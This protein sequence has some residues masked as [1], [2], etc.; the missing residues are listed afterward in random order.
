[1][2]TLVALL[3]AGYTLEISGEFEKLYSSLSRVAST[4]L[5]IRANEELHSIDNSTVA[6]EAGSVFERK[7]AHDLNR[8]NF[9]DRTAA[10]ASKDRHSASGVEAT[11]KA[12][13]VEHDNEQKRSDDVAAELAAVRAELADR[14]NTEA[15]A[16]KEL[17]DAANRL[18]ANEK[19]WAAK[20]N[21]EQERSNAVARDLAA[22]RAEL[23]YRV[24]MDAAARKELVDS[25][26]RL[27]ANEKEW[28]A[29][30]NAEREQSNAVARDSAPLRGEPPGRSTTEHSARLE[31]AAPAGQATGH[32]LA[33]HWQIFTDQN[34]TR[35]EYPSDLFP[36]V[37]TSHR[38]HTVVTSDG[39]ASLDIYAGP[40]ERGETP[41]QVL[42]RTVAEKRSLL[43][44]NRIAPNF[45]AISAFHKDRILY[46]R[47]N[48]K[49]G[50]IHCIDL[51]YPSQE[52]R[53][54]DAP[55]TRIS[56]SLR[57]L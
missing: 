19:E 37:R 43:T 27:E 57:P 11:D 45:F 25:T 38:G 41:G 1:V 28:A 4:A 49:G 34:G 9:A 50:M 33:E 39:R 2:L 47:C 30:L 53:A 8:Q 12:R 10:Q 48:F 20:L 36:I 21:A 52:K 22:A 56:R 23:A 35:V 54:W 15:K 32:G 24:K 40:N 55:V 13:K 18:K 5:R 42:R 3:T 26:K 51:T 7:L 29:K 46:R 17:A 16:R 44:Y 31:I 6:A 14:V